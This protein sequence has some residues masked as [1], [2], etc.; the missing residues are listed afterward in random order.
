[1]VAPDILGVDSLKFYDMMGSLQLSNNNKNQGVFMNFLF[2]ATNATD[3]MAK[4]KVPKVKVPLSFEKYTELLDEQL[5]E[6]YWKYLEDFRMALLRVKD[7][8]S[9]EVLRTYIEEN[10]WS[11]GNFFPDAVSFFISFKKEHDVPE[12]LIRPLLAH[13]LQECD[14]WKSYLES[15]LGEAVEDLDD[16]LDLDEDEDEE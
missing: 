13:V 7:Q 10:Y 8:G 16:D 12:K 14:D 4:V 9:E 5:H 1:M 11:F 6:E 2:K 15:I 3:S